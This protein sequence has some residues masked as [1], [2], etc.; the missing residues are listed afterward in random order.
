MCVRKGET[1]GV[2]TLMCHEEANFTMEISNVLH[3]HAE[4]EIS[5]LCS[6]QQSGGITAAMQ[7][8]RVTKEP[9]DLVKVLCV[10]AG[11]SPSSPAPSHSQKHACK[12]NWEL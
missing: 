8:V 4:T 11:F 7:S 12:A 6:R 1:S 2:S 3:R 5:H 10:S 9:R